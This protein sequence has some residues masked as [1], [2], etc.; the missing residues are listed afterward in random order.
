MR[1]DS[2]ALVQEATPPDSEGPWRDALWLRHAQSAAPWTLPSVA[3]AMTGLYP[4]GHGTGAFRSKIANLTTEIPTGIDPHVTTL[5]ER[6]G[7]AGFE[8]HALVAHPWL[9][10]TGFQRGFDHFSVHSGLDARI[11]MLEEVERW[12]DAREAAIPRR[13]FLLYLHFMEAHQHPGLSQGA[14]HSRIATLAPGLRSQ[15]EASAPGGRHLRSN[16]KLWR[17]YL[18]YTA[19]VALLRDAVTRLL[20]TLEARELLKETV[21]VVFSDHGEEFL[22]HVEAET[23]RAIDPRGTFGVGHGHSLYQEQ[24]HVPLIIWHPAL[25]GGTSEVSV[26]LV[27][28]A[29]TLLDWLGVEGQSGDG[30]SMSHS[31]AGGSFDPQRPLYASGVAFGPRRGAVLSGRHKLISGG[32]VVP[33]LEFDLAQD[34]LEESPLPRVHADLAALLAAHRRDE[35]LDGAPPDID[36]E[37]LTELQEL[38]YLQDAKAD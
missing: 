33:D 8:T 17:Q 2:L 28:I 6:L 30:R 35:N 1:Y 26:S 24:L 10:A 22:D 25:A 9:H 37:T 3:S 19:A 32:A 21:V 4:N 18:A 29:P 34:P 31:L 20:D 36:A 14:L 38:G 11:S 5:A 27:D 7:R 15:A 13:H 23:A 12:L 16:P